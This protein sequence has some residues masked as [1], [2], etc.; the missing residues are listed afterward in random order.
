MYLYGVGFG[1]AAQAGAAQNATYAP[2]IYSINGSGGKDVGTFSASVTLGAFPTINGGLPSAIIRSSG[3]TLSW[4]GA[5]PAA[6]VTILGLTEAVS[7]LTFSLGE[8]LCSTTA[9]SGTFTVPASIL[10]Q[11]PAS[12]TG[13]LSVS[14]N[15]P[16]V[17]FS[18]PLT[19]GGTTI[20]AGFSASFSLSNLPAYQ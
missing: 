16:T 19:G 1:P 18:A 5:N 9:A 4:T 17:P 12:T 2:G 11:I 10:S 13:S 20:N 6:T 14:F 15:N 3:L 8:F 7:G